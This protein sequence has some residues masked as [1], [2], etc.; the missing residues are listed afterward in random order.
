MTNEEQWKKNLDDA[1]LVTTDMVLRHVDMVKDHEKWLE[2]HTLAMLE[3]NRA[4]KRHDEEMAEIRATQ[5]D[6]AQQLNKLAK[7]L[8]GG[9]NG[10][11]Q[12]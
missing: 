8:Q 2:S 4:I 10:H 11:G 12:T 5:A 3:H 7:I 9:G 6:T 1:M